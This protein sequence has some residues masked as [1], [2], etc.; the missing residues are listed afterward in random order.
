[1]T[2]KVISSVYCSV[3]KQNSKKVE[4]NKAPNTKANHVTSKMLEVKVCISAQLLMPHRLPFYVLGYENLD[5]DKVSF[6]C[7]D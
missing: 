4:K 7:F 5:L 6:H 2:G 3:M 1:M